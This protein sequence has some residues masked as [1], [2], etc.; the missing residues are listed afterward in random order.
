M[1]RK[2]VVDFESEGEHKRSSRLKK[3]DWL[4]GETKVSRNGKKLLTSKAKGSINAPRALRKT[5]N[6]RREKLSR[7]EKK[8]LTRGTKEGI[9]APRAKR[10]RAGLAGRRGQVVH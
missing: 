8:L 9:N 1:K 2:K 7:N 5:T 6:G 3:N 10:Q 4:H